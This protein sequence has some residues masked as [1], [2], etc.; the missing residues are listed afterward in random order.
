MAGFAYALIALGFLGATFLASLDAYEVDWPF[1]A[2]TILT[3]FLGVLLLKRTR[4]GA[5]RQVHVLHGNRETLQASLARIID[6]LSAF[7]PAAAEIAVDEI[8][9]EVDR[10]FR[11][12]LAAFVEA[13]ESLIHLYGMKIYAGIMS[14]FAAGERYLNRAWSASTDG[15]GEEARDY[16]GRALVQF[17]EAGAALEAAG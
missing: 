3:G 13:R 17:R 8:R 4:R 11:A 6:G 15:Y 10:R 12:D 14:H 5:A 9:H 2:G 1:F 7:E 16:L